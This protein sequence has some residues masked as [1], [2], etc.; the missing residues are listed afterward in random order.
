MQWR[1]MRHN[2]PTTRN[3]K[4][5]QDQPSI[6]PRRADQ[7]KNIANTIVQL[8]TIFDNAQVYTLQTEE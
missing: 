3:R 6:V 7:S 4:C 2:H 1:Q 5:G 8:T